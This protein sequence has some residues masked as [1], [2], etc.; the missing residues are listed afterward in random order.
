VSKTLGNYMNLF[1]LGFFQ[2][3]QLSST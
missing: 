3:D 1:S 2:S